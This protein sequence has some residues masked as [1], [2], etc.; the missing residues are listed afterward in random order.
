MAGEAAGEPRPV[1][2]GGNLTALGRSLLSGREISAVSVS[3]WRHRLDAAAGSFVAGVAW[4]L[5]GRKVNI[6]AV[7]AVAARDTRSVKTVVIG[8]RLTL[9]N[10]CGSWQ[11]ERKGRQQRT[12]ALGSRLYACL[13]EAGELLPVRESACLNPLHSDLFFYCV[14]CLECSDPVSPQV[15]FIA[16]HPAIPAYLLSSCRHTIFRGCEFTVSWPL[17]VHCSCALDKPKPEDARMV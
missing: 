12:A 13:S 9:P 10:R 17:P 2:R 4:P 8:W 14:F 1:P 11:V 6:E 3:L 5:L 7:A 16:Y 15:C